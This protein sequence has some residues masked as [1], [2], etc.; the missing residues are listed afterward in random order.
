MTITKKSLRLVIHGR[1]QGVF[2]RDSIRREAQ[3]LSVA[4]WVRNRSDGAVEAAVQGAPAAVDAIVHWA[5]RGP[6]HAQVTRVDIKPDDG[7]YTSFDV[8]D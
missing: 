7:S 5:Q 3:H 6:Q 2:F 8:I 4:G 1:V